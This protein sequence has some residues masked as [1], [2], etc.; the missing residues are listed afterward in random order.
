MTAPFESMDLSF[1]GGV[2][3]SWTSWPSWC[4]MMW[5]MYSNTAYRNVAQWSGYLWKNG[6]YASTR[7]IFNP[8][9]RVVQFYASS[10][11][12]GRLTTDPEKDLKPG[13]NNAIPIERPAKPELLPALDQL[14]EWSNWQKGKALLPRYGAMT[15]GVLAEIF[16]NVE[17]RTVSIASVWPG[18]TQNIILDSAGNVKGYDIAYEM[19]DEI[20]GAPFAYR[21]KVDGRVIR[22]YKNN[23][24]WDREGIPAVQSNPYGFAPAVWVPHIDVGGP[25]GLSAVHSSMTKIQELASIYSHIA[26]H[27]HKLISSPMVLTGASGFSGRDQSGRA[28]RRNELGAPAPATSAALRTQVPFLFAP[29]GAGLLHLTGNL[30][31]PDG[32]ALADDL[33]QDIYD[34]LIELTSYKDLRAMSS[35]TGPAAA[36]LM[37]DVSGRLMDAQAQYDLQSKKLFQM[38]VAIAGWRA[39]E[40]Y[41]GLVSSLTEQQKK[42]LPFDLES[43][44]KG[45]L[46]FRIGDRP[47]IALTPEEQISRDRQQMALENDKAETSA[48]DAFRQA[49]GEGQQQAE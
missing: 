37:G 9:Y 34:D 23:Q 30:S 18:H 33:K 40:G 25:I 31:I 26:D 14:W 46:D 28:T 29:A 27:G 39:K 38:A 42:F 45:D 4:D 15:G 16:D 43:W 11:Y 44:R 21:K 32:L 17:R 5:Q 12:P 8:T 48:M 41:W 19:A 36:R 7:P 6:L 22:H 2:V 35:V 1:P 10:V 20:S 3:D 13:S 49:T 47:L 24:P